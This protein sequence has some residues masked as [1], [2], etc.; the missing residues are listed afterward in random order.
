M[1]L[2]NVLLFLPKR[3][4]RLSSA[5]LMILLMSG[6][7]RIY[8]FR[9]VPQQHVL[10]ACIRIMRIVAGRRKR[11]KIKGSKGHDAPHNQQYGGARSEM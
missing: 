5:S 9:N 2:V 3:E 6:L 11:T 8:R 10:L 1:L 7:R 4:C